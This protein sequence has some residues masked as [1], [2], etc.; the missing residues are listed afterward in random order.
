MSLPRFGLLNNAQ[1]DYRLVV[2][3]RAEGFR[4]ELRHRDPDLIRG[5]PPA[6]DSGPDLMHQ[7]LQLHTY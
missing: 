4:V 3:S 7:S 1:S 6:E 2:R 5:V